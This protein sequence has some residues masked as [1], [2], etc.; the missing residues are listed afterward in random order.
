MIVAVSLSLLTFTLKAADEKINRSPVDLVLAKDES[1]L[2]TVNQT[3][4]SVS[5]VRVADGA[6]L[7]EL[8]IGR[9]PAAIALHPNGKHILATCSYSGDVHL[10][11][12]QNEKL[13]A[14]AIIS[15]GFQPNGIAITPD[16]RTFYVA[17]TDADQ[18][19]VIDFN[20]R[21]ITRRIDVGRWPRYLAL[22]NDQTRL[23]VAT[24]GD[25]G[26]SVIDTETQKLLHIDR[27]VGLNIGHM[28]L[29]RDGNQVYFPWMVY[30]R[31]PITER[32]IR[33][34]W[35]MASRLGRI[36]L[37]D[38][39]RREAISIDVPGKAVADPHGL[40]ITSDEGNVVISASGTHEL[41]V[42]KVP[43]LP[44]QDRGSTDHIDEQLLRDDSR[45]FRIETGGRPMGLRISK[46]DRMVYV[47]N[48]LDNSIQVVD[49]AERKIVRRFHL[50]GG[51]TPS[52][53][54]QG[55][56]I[57]FDARRSLDQWYSC[58]SCHY[59]GGSNAVVMDTMND[60]TQFSFKTV[61]PLYQLDATGPWTWHG[62]QS[63]LPD[64]MK[65][66]F[67]TP[68]SDRIPATPI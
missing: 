26:I 9:R 8:T 18:V 64:A 25:R 33:L 35:V 6:L 48:Y 54:R 22:S 45:F 42:L 10:L 21:K 20:K 31:N 65:H 11:E 24:S 55:E 4:D 66:S 37:D 67:K 15:L 34:G 46:D 41:L 13:H 43:G 59:E 19:A 1:W 14:V 16:G 7:D 62:W 47:A 44:F 30:R 58:H 32:N 39:A 60:G 51:G 3:S 61:L 53:A 23:A 5:L 2:A 52:L 38:T 27:F 36:C 68:C 63:S 56:A 17:L 29:S 40:A 12:V 49:L 50:G 57:F 28:Q